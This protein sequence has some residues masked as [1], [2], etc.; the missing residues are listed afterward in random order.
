[1]LE[2]ALGVPVDLVPLDKAPPKLRLKTLSEAADMDVKLK[3]TH[4]SHV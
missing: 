3:R 2:D 1:M 4:G